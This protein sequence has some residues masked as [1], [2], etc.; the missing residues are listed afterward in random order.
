MRRNLTSL[1]FFND[2]RIPVIAAIKGVCIGSA[3]ELALFCHFRLCTGNAVLGLP[4]STY[5]LMPGLG[6]IQLLLE[7]VTKARAMEMVFRG[8]T[9]SA[10]EG[11]KTGI[12]DRIFPKD[13]LLVAAEKLIEIA[14]VNY[15]KYNKNEYLH[16]LDKALRSNE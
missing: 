16:H 13:Q 10:D 1:K 8:T 2:L 11:L 14:A 7:H 9:L 15:R 6:G 5:G 4:E 3:C 12:I